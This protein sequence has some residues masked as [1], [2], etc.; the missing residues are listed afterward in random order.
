M[1]YVAGRNLANLLAEGR[2]FTP[3]EAAKLLGQLLDALGSI[4]AAGIVHRD[5]KPANLLL[6]GELRLKLTDFGIARMDG[7]GL[8]QTGALIGTPSLYVARAMPRRDG[9]CAHRSLH[10]R[11]PTA[12]DADRRAR[13]R[14][15]ALLAVSRRI[16]EDPPP[17]L[18]A[19]IL[20]RGAGARDGA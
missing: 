7:T 20:R 18:P 10:R 5:L 12:R 17:P 16:L 6:H 14:Q 11:R 19:A 13:L 2:R 9:G 1:E 15:G 8:T 4:H 3:T